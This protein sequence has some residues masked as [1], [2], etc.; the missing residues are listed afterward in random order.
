LQVNYGLMT[1]ENGVPVSISVYDGNT[2]DST[3]VLDQVDI[4]QNKLPPPIQR[5]CTTVACIDAIPRTGHS[6][7]SHAPYD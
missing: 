3:T 4:L 6:P 1:N 5:V 7:R 2:A